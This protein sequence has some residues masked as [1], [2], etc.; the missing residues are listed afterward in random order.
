[1][2]ASNR[3]SMI[4]DKGRN[5]TNQQEP[6]DLPPRSLAQARWN[7]PASPLS[8][9]RLGEEGAGER[10]GDAGGEQHEKRE[11]L[12]DSVQCQQRF[13]RHDPGAGK[14][15]PEYLSHGHWGLALGN[16]FEQEDDK[17]AH[18][19]RSRIKV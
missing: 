12:E 7:W 10:D 11:A 16:V 15:E 8:G 6:C 19:T 4:M 17:E 1:M 3:T 9:G 5:E 13:G 2:N 14:Q 18:G